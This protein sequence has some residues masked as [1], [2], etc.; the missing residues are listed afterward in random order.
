VSRARVP[1]DSAAGIERKYHPGDSER[2]TFFRVL[3]FKKGLVGI[4][5]QFEPGIPQRKSSTQSFLRI[6]QYFAETAPY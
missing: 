6:V 5:V 2:A 3:R 4:V 1:R